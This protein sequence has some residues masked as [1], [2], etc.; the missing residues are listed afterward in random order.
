L[1]AAATEAFRYE[2]TQRFADE[3]GRRV[4]ESVDDMLVDEHDA[5]QP[6]DDHHGGWNGL[7][8][9][10]R[11]GTPRAAANGRFHRGTKRFARVAHWP[12]SYRARFG[13]MS[14]LAPAV[15]RRCAGP[16]VSPAT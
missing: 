4:T 1:P 8:C 5:L 6:V 2:P 14:V 10:E 9:H 7:E 12:V 16:H 15:P 13:G 3:L 11:G